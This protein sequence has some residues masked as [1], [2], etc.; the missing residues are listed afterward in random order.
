MNTSRKSPA[1][2]LKSPHFCPFARPQSVHPRH[3]ERGNAMIYILIAIVLFAALG[4]ILA[5][6][7]DNSET[8][9]LNSERTEIAATQVI[10]TSMQ[11]KQAIDQMMYSGTKP[12]QLDFIT[13]DKEPGFST[14]PHHNKVFHPG[15]GG[16]IVN[17]LPAQAVHQ[18]STTPPARW[19]IGRPIN[20][21]WSP[22][23]TQDVII[24]AHQISEPVCRAINQ[25]LLGDPTPLA[26][27]INPRQLLISSSVY[28]GMG[29][30]MWQN[31][32]CPACVEKI[33][34]CMTGPSEVPGQAIFSFYSIAVLL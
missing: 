25:K 15:G 26:S 23:N 6:Q 28:G 2:G 17:P 32:H 8:S 11:L 18:V 9:A 4:V 10:Q 7:S 27:T 20:V 12:H 3:G 16:V 21:Q 31:A 19:Y 24:T 29:L 22:S 30:P 33:A 1:T 13:P 14:P 5:R 34:G